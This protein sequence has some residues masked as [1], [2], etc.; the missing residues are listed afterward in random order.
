MQTLVGPLVDVAGSLVGGWRSPKAIMFQ[1]SLSSD[2]WISWNILSP[3]DRAELDRNR[4]WRSRH[5]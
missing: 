4:L 5:A 2:F 1:A 3:L